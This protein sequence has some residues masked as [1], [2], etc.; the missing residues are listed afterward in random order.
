MTVGIPKVDASSP[1]RPTHA[2]QDRDAVTRQMGFPCFQF[3]CFDRKANMQRSTSVVR[4]DNASGQAGL[5]V[6][7]PSN[8]Q[9]QHVPATDIQGTEPGGVL[10]QNSQPHEVTIEPARP[11][12]IVHIERGFL[13]VAKLRHFWSVHNF[14]LPVSQR[15]VTD[16][17]RDISNSDDRDF[18]A[19]SPDE[20]FYVVWV[21]REN[22]GFL[23]KGGRHHNSVH[24]IRRFR[25]A[26]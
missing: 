4:R 1:Q 2:A 18:A 17:L 14:T 9:Q 3:R 26:Q 6:A 21:A 22:R 12:E 20:P 13:D 25:L 10:R 8:K 11:P 7:S 23:P 19:R 15:A 16:R 5:R 24:D